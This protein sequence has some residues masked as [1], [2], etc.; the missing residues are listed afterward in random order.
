M[1]P[2]YNA[3][4]SA[5]PV[6]DEPPPDEPSEASPTEPPNPSR[7]SACSGAG[8]TIEIEDTTRSLDDAS[9]VLL[10]SACGTACRLAGATVGEVR[11][12]L[13]GDDEMARQHKARCGVRGTTDV[14]TFN[15]AEG[16]SEILDADLL[17]CIDEASR[18][19]GLRG[20]DLSR[21]LLLYVLHGVLHCLGFDDTDD[22]AY[23]KMHAREDEILGS[24]GVGETFARGEAGGAAS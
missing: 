2:T 7:S 11:V 10:R 18:Q 15:L 13:V 12:R 5:H 19:A 8:P 6:S 4:E 20:H 9:I 17:V 24:M 3:D 14:I 16:G 22:E 21:E 23:A 1:T